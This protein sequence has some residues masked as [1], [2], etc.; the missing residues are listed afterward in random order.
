MLSLVRAEVARILG[1]KCEAISA[2]YDGRLLLEEGT[3]AWDKGVLFV[4][5]Y[6]AL[7]DAMDGEE[8]SMVHWLRRE[9]KALGTSPFYRIVDEGRLAEIVEY[10]LE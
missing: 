7:Y 6:Q 3:E 2:L 4:R 10:L 8:A 1:L 5:F 9:H